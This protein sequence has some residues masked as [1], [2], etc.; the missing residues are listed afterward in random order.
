MKIKEYRAWL[1]EK[2]IMVSVE[3]INYKTKRIAY[4]DED[5]YSG[6]PVPELVSFDNIILMPAVN[7]YEI[8]NNERGDQ[9]YLDDI[10]IL[11]NSQGIFLCK[12]VESKNIKVIEGYEVVL[13]KEL[14]I[15]YNTE[16]NTWIGND[17]KEYSEYIEVS[18]FIRIIG[19]KYENLKMWELDK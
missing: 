7:L 13:L 11:N 15:K 8:R 10:L 16:L 19:N 3:M 5:I 12:V 6:Y 14:D 1:K 17:S 4:E 2:E 9:V 18:N